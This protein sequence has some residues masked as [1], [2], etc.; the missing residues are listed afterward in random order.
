MLIPIMN[1]NRKLTLILIF[2]LQILVTINQEEEML[3]CLI[4]HIKVTLLA[5]LVTIFCSFRLAHIYPRVPQ[6]T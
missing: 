2:M 1:L 5:S 4:P 6:V 3:Y